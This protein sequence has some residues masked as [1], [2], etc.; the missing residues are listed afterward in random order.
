MRRIIPP[1]SLVL[2]L[3]VCLPQVGCTSEQVEKLKAALT[4]TQSDLERVEAAIEDAAELRAKVIQAVQDMPPGPDRD[5]AIEVVEKLDKVI[6]TGQEWIAKANVT[7]QELNKRLEDTTDALGVTEAVLQTAAPFIPPPWGTLVAGIGVGVIGLIRSAR[8]KATAKKVIQSVNPLI[9][10]LDL[11]KN[12]K[13]Q[14][15]LIQGK[16]GKKLVDEAQGKKFSLP[17]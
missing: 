1:L 9:A 6:T 3:L 11:R 7:L 12:Q 10:S 17:I 14:I 8:T 4:N 5:R 15:A 16:A 2:L 13:D